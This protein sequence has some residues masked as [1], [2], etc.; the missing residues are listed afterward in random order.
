MKMIPGEQKGGGWGFCVEG[1][2]LRP[3]VSKAGVSGEGLRV[4]GVSLGEIFW[5]I[6]GLSR[7][8]PESVYGLQLRGV[9]SI[10]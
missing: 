2:G 8:Q 4:E 5:W 10:C 6:D 3:P 9:G 1:L 7:S